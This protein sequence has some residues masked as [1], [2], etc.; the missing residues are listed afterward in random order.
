MRY[1][2]F[3]LALSLCV[4]LGAAGARAQTGDPDPLVAAANSGFGLFELC[5][6]GR[7]LMEWNLH[8]LQM[9][10]SF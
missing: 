6:N 3:C 7:Q 4:G 5:R 1:W 9:L 2:G 10:V 8:A